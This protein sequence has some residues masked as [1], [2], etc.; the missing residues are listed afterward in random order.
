MTANLD[1]I[2]ARFGQA[3]YSPEFWKAVNATRRQESEK[4]EREEQQAMVAN[5]K[6]LTKRYDL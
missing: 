2:M 1:E 6:L 5:H 3:S 4:W